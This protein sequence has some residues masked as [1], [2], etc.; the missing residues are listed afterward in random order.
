MRKQRLL[1]VSANLLLIFALLMTACAPAVPA[2]CRQQ[3]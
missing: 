3:Q 1:A 2:G